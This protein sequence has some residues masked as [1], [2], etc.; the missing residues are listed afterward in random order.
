M[1]LSLKMACLT[2]VSNLENHV[3]NAIQVLEVSKNFLEL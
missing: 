2:K 1:N 3:N